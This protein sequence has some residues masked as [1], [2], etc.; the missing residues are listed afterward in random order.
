[1]WWWACGGLLVL[2]SVSFQCLLTT[3]PGVEFAVVIACCY[4]CALHAW[5][6][7]VSQKEKFEAR[8]GHKSLLQR[9]CSKCAACCRR[10]A[11]AFASMCMCWSSYVC[12]CC[13][14][15]G[16]VRR[17]NAARVGTT[18]VEV[19]E[20][21]SPEKSMASPGLLSLPT[22]LPSLS[23]I[24][25]LATKLLADA[26]GRPVLRVGQRSRRQGRQSAKWGGGR[27][28]GGGGGVGEDG[29]GRAGGFGGLWTNPVSGGVDGALTPLANHDRCV[30][31][32]VF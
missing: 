18:D 27:G 8:S 23:A 14:T 30:F 28:R 1:M 7:W 24:D 20:G 26:V 29:L 4:A 9:A 19:A 6:S 25:T 10:R 21:P 12:C 3:H 22:M 13:R 16:R 17:I 11:P 2:Q 5:Y 15:C 32:C 31:S